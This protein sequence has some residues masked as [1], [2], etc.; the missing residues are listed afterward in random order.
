MFGFGSETFWLNLVNVAFGVVSAAA[1]VAILASVGVEIVQRIRA[2]MATRVHRPRT[3]P[4]S[5]RSH[6][7]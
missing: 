2:R 3:I 4:L 6:T 1:I 7:A 5:A